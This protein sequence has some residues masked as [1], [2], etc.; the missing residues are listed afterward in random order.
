MKIIMKKTIAL[1]LFLVFVMGFAAAASAATAVQ[2]DS[3]IADT[4]QYIY[5]TVKN[6]QVGSVGGEWAVLGLARSGY[7]VPEKYFQDYYTTVESYVKACGGVLHKKKYTEYSRVAVALTSIGRD[8]RDVAGYNLLTALGD[9]EK[10]I[11]QGIN[12]PVW[13]LIALDSGNYPM[14]ENPDAEI[15]ATRNMYVDE[16]LRRQLPDGGFSLFGGTDYATEGDEASDPDITG[17]ALQALAKY[18]HRSDVRKVT[19]EALSRLSAL[20]NNDGG[21]ASWGTANSESCVQV[22]VALTELG[23][24]LEDSRFV[25]QG[26]MLVDNLLTFYMEGRGF[27]HTADGSGSNQMATEQGFYGLVAA[28]RAEN[29]K[30]SLYRM[31][32]AIS[33]PDA[34]YEGPK[35]GEGLYGKHSDVSAVPVARPGKTFADISAHV[36][37]PAVEALAARGVINGKTEDIF[38]PEA[39]MTRAEFAAIVVRGLG[40]GENESSVFSDVASGSWYAG[41]VGTA[42]NYGIVKGVSD[43]AFYPEGT[44]T[45]EQAAVM[46][47]G[48]ARLCG[49]D[50]SLSDGTVRDILAQFT[51]Y[52]TSSGWARTSLAFCYREDILS[53]DDLD[54]RPKVPIKR[55]EVAEMLFRM[56]G[57]L[58]LL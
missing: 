37:R 13:A 58:N 31:D 54:I 30:N 52:V 27:L 12:G 15:Q 11:W 39:T 20:Q 28:Q 32:D 23:I 38:D 25:K 21:F 57:V 8:P 3:V 29:G 53:K 33:I 19:E 7:E 16:I 55:C 9:F 4:A 10:T 46:A 47:A 40:L 5:K 43:T 56:L 2:L 50:T 6:P 48:A 42:Y 14:P 17:M 51:D 34:V 49:M 26:N 1:V 44:I 18:Q 35:A 45:R 36:N 24:S 41:Y 22:I